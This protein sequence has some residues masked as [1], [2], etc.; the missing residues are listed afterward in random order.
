VPSRS[1]SATPAPSSNQGASNPPSPPRS[2]PS[3]TVLGAQTTA[4]SASGSLPSTA[5]VIGT[6]RGGRRS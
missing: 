6:G 2:S 5:T 4:P 3:P 1:P